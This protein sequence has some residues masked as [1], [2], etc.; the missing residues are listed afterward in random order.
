MDTAV[1]GQWVEGTQHS[2]CRDKCKHAL[3][4]KIDAISSL[5]NRPSKLD[6]IPEQRQQTAHLFKV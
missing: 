3:Q 6:E 2:C 1:L 4:C 5:I